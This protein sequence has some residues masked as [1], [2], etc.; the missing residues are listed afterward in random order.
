M[1]KHSGTQ[2][3]SEPSIVGQVP[4]G[5]MDLFVKMIQD[6]MRKKAQRSVEGQKT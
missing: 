1:K 3:D 5:K 2:T 6:S 4:E